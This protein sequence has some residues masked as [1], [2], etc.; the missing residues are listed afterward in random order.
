MRRAP[1]RSAGWPPPASEISAAPG[2][3]DLT[4]QL[5]LAAAAADEVGEPI[6]GIRGVVAARRF[7]LRHVDEHRTRPARGRLADQCVALLRAEIVV[8]LAGDTLRGVRS[9]S[10][11]PSPDRAA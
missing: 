4:R 8:L 3:I 10:S 11:G 7:R 1:G 9:G 5:V 6:A 2:P